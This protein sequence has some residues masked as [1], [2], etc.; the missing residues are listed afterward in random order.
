M[1]SESKQGVHVR[2]YST[3][4]WIEYFDT[5]PLPRPMNDAELAIISVYVFGVPLRLIRLFSGS[6]EVEQNYSD[7]HGEEFAFS[8]NSC[9]GYDRSAGF[10]NW[11]CGELYCGGIARASYGQFNVQ[12]H[13]N[14]ARLLRWQVSRREDK[15]RTPRTAFARLAAHCRKR[16]NSEIRGVAVPI[17][18]PGGWSR[19]GLNTTVMD[20]SKPSRTS[21]GRG[22]V[23]IRYLR[24]VPF[25]VWKRV[26]LQV[27]RLFQVVRSD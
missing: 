16:K 22:Q 23:I 18:E 24:P 6:Y 5:L 17:H 4:E 11:A 1:M 12:G 25:P 27:K 15:G 2:R 14:S 7:Y 19:E 20:C 10:W 26:W 13:R 8:A 9:E 3:H 21:E